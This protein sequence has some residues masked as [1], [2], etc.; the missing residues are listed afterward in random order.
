M[1][2]H[3][4]EQND[5]CTAS[6][7]DGQP[8]SVKALPDSAFCYFHDPENQDALRESRRRG[9][10]NK[11]RAREH[12]E[13]PG[14][15]MR[16][17]GDVLLIVEAATADAFKLEASERRCRVVGY[18]AGVALKALE[19]KTVE[20]IEQRLTALEEQQRESTG[21]RRWST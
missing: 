13:A 19:V 21:N 2:E 7:K 5:L 14:E 17:V 3:E 9:G 16:S 15:T 20:E 18:L 12:T 8:C 1:S 10:H 4:G 6:K 11:R